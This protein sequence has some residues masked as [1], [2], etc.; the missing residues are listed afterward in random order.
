M[1]TPKPPTDT[2]LIGAEGAYY[3]MAR[4]AGLGW[5]PALTPRGTAGIDI[6]ATTPTAG[7]PQVRIQSKATQARSWER[8]ADEQE[9]RTAA[10]R[11]A[12]LKLLSESIFYVL[13]KRS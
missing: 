13:C 7:G 4:L 10:A 3:V 2:A 12:T 6:L 1:T 5:I 9:G 8:M 11:A